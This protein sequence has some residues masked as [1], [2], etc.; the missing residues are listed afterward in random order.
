M[1]RRTFWFASGVAAGVWATTKVNRGL[2]RLAPDSLAATAADRAVTVGGRLRDRAVLFAGDV[3]ENMVH[4]EAQLGEALGLT[5]PVDPDL[6]APRR[7]TA[8][9]N[10]ND[11]A[12]VDRTTRPHNRNEDH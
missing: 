6:P 7:Y 1:F 4:R 8:I 10:R 2:R 3:R 5:A 9:E 11:P 12:R